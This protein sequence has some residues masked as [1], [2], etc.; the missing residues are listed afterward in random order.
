MRPDSLTVNVRGGSRIC[1]PASLDRITCYV[2]L[3]QED[4]F[5][6]EI[7]F[8]RRWLRPGMH[9]VDVGAN[10][11]VYTVAMAQAVGRGGRVWAFEPT[12]QTAEFLQRTLE[13]N[14]C[15]QA[16]VIRTALSDRGGSVAFALNPDS[17]LNA[18]AAPGAA[19]REVIT[20]PAMSL[21]QAAAEHDWSRVDLVKLDV[22]G[23]ELEV[24][25][26]GAEFLSSASPL[27]MFEIK[28]GDRLDLRVLTPLAEMGYDFY[29]LIPG[30]LILT[31]MEALETI[32][33]YQLNLF[34][35]KDDRRRQLEIEGSIADS[36]MA[37][38][39]K[40]DPGAWNAYARTAPYAQELVLR[41]PSKAGFFVGADVKAYRE[42]LAAFAQSRDPH[43]AVGERF[44]LLKLAFSR[45][46]QA[47]ESKNTLARRISYARLAWELGAREAAVAALAQCASDLKAG[48]EQALA[49]PFLAPSARSEQHATGAPAGEWLECAVL[50]QY[51][52][53]RAHSSFF[54]GSDAL[55]LLESVSAR[56]YRSPEMERRRQLVRMRCGVQ[57]DP[58]SHPL[59]AERTD[60][61]LN[62]DFWS[63]A[64]RLA[65]R[66]GTPRNGLTAADA[67]RITSLLPDLLPVKIVDVGAMSLGED[68]D[69]YARL[70]E[71]I[72]CE[73][74]GFEPVEEE[75][76][77]L[78]R[79]AR[80]GCCYLPYVIGD[81]SVQ[82]FHECNFP[83]TSS[84]LEPNTA[85]LAKFED[86]EELVRVVATRTVTTR[87]LDDIPEARG[88]DYL[89]LDVQ[90]GE[91]MV[92]RGARELLK[93][94]LVV[95]T[96]VEFVPLYKN[97][98]LFADLDAFLRGQGFALHRIPGFAG[99]PFKLFSAPHKLDG[100]VSQ[101]LWCDA[102]YVRDFMTFDRLSL[103]Q[104]LKLS[105]ILHQNYG[106]YD[107]AAL[108]LEAHDRKTGA[109][110][111][112]RYLR[113]GAAA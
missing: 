73:I 72:R 101:L 41:W 59:L 63:A 6:D 58:E 78:N 11:G 47:L 7:R 70:T 107:L 32:D 62:P 28:A 31:P 93:G 51:E 23:H 52:K 34:A 50:E 80:P 87:R 24:I 97:Q 56:H 10:F 81:G 46:A 16:T 5:E 26:G 27:L 105:A 92:L 108:A 99:R 102:V 39:D 57:S 55:P 14:R 82:M 4:W 48:R 12:P 38:A 109:D 40:L 2:L 44:A 36:D 37:R 60:E 76:E 13:L 106:S 54:L 17:E 94:V 61:N 98:P 74:V 100:T 9:A 112:V 96:E 22:E 64:G 8:V 53:L 95:H 84:L 30:M 90:G 67:F 71:A 15:A 69:P 29:R 85:L 65:R 91:L 21:S 113:R 35:C 83:M 49:E 33:G 68:N 104:L 111:A 110:L 25:T 1:V 19:A 20:V 89:K 3:E 77:K 66:V 79:N 42:G 43:H 88:A 18:I 75:C 103:G 86:L 45:V